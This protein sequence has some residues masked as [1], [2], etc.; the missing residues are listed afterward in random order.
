MMKTQQQ[1]K[2]QNNKKIQLKLIFYFLAKETLNAMKALI[3]NLKNSKPKE[4]SIIKTAFK[5]PES[6]TDDEGGESEDDLEPIIVFE[7]VEPYTAKTK[8]L[9]E[10]QKNEKKRQSLVP[11]PAPVKVIFSKNFNEKTVTIQLDS[12]TTLVTSNAITKNLKN[13]KEIEQ[14]KAHVTR[15]RP[16]ISSLL[17]TLYPHTEL[18]IYWNILSVS[19]RLVD[20]NGLLNNVKLQTCDTFDEAIYHLANTIKT[21][22]ASSNNPPIG[23][24]NGTFF[25]INARLTDYL[26]DWELEDIPNPF[27]ELGL[28][29]KF[30]D[31]SSFDYSKPFGY[32]KLVATNN[33][34]AQ[35]TVH[36][37]LGSPAVPSSAVVAVTREQVEAILDKNVQNVY[38][39]T[40][41]K[42]C[43]TFFSRFCPTRSSEEL[44]T[45]TQK[46]KKLKT[47]NISKTEVI[48]KNTNHAK[49]QK[50]TEVE[51]KQKQQQQAQFL[52][53]EPK[54]LY[55][56]VYNTPKKLSFAERFE[57]REKKKPIVTWLFEAQQSDI[58]QTGKTTETN[59]ISDNL[60][61]DPRNLH[62]FSDKHQQLHPKNHWIFILRGMFYYQDQP[63]HIVCESA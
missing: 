17:T 12:P 2:L 6:D 63:Y 44:W 33:S 27:F 60:S 58:Y 3:K 32:I 53:K 7:P 57:N 11:S 42:K 55:K 19:K 43:N 34:T 50:E 40:I 8:R 54:Q 14:C 13:K 48:L 49:Q 46:L 41:D 37:L 24:E 56:M 23:E 5:V 61:F 28:E 30:V 62:L 15:V 10:E 18:Y 22:T 31:A 52:S 16:P 45:K 59:S 51:L 29:N 47:N 35:N 39:S 20:S 1:V 36:S 4:G 9:L 26:F 21:K 25:L 38:R